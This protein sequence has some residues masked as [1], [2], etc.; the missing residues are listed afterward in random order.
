MLNKKGYFCIS[1]AALELTRPRGKYTPL[2]AL[3]DL[4]AKANIAPGFDTIR[5][6]RVTVERGQTARSVVTLSDTWNWSRNR[7][8]NFLNQLE[9]A[10]IIKQQKT[11]VTTLITILNYDPQKGNETASTTANETAEPEKQSSRLSSEQSTIELIINNKTQIPPVSPRSGGNQPG[12]MFVDGV[13]G[14]GK[15]TGFRVRRP[16]VKFT[17][18][19]LAEVKELVK[20]E[21]LLINPEKFF[22][23]Y[24]GS[25]WRGVVSWQAKARAWNADEIDKTAKKQPDI[26]SKQNFDKP[27]KEFKKWRD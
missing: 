17:P 14:N 9:N 10:Q 11:N 7:T 26:T 18:P 19:T 5:G 3:I 16:R 24:E 6:Q 21:S 23:T 1:R 15:R 4:V 2:E 20:A 27:A 8:A 13:D 22:H 12:F 25:N